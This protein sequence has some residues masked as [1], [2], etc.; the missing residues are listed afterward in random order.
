MTKQLFASS[1]ILLLVT[2][3]L[4]CGSGGGSSSKNSQPKS[5]QGTWNITVSAGPESVTLKVVLVPSACAVLTN[6]GGFD[7]SGPVCFIA[8]NQTGQGSMSSTGDLSYPPQMV[9]VGV[10]Q[11]QIPVGTAVAFNLLYLEADSGYAFA[12]FDGAGTVTNGVTT[13]TYNCSMLGG[14]LCAIPS[15]TFTGTEQ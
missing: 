12:V 7:V 5:V 9:L 4:G 14:E 1:T 8:D 2:L 11:D 10:P 15:G 3:A 13:G 6:M